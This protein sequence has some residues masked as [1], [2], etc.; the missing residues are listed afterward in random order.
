[1]SWRSAPVEADR[2]GGHPR[3]IPVHPQTRPWPTS[4]DNARQPTARRWIPATI[5]K[6]RP[7]RPIANSTMPAPGDASAVAT[8][9]EPSPQAGHVEPTLARSPAMRAKADVSVA[10]AHRQTDAPERPLTRL[11]PAGRPS[12]KPNAL[13]TTAREA[14]GPAIGDGHE[15]GGGGATPVRRIGATLLHARDQR[16]RGERRPGK[17]TRRQLRV[18]GDD[19]TCRPFN[20]V[21]VE[22]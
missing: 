8:D 1:M 2:V 14:P 5:R 17:R 15:P 7:S 9:T 12:H 18:W 11:A 4:S 3:T 13:R 21:V 22:A 19:R 10:Q 16:P 6:S 20:P